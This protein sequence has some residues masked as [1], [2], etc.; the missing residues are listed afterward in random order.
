MF[1]GAE[2]RA[3]RKRG[4]SDVQACRFG[5][6]CLAALFLSAPAAR[7]QTVGYIIA[8]QGTSISN[9]SGPWARVAAGDPI[10]LEF[11]STGAGLPVASGLTGLD[12]PSGAELDPAAWG[13][14]RL[15]VTGDLGAGPMVIEAAIV[16]ASVRPVECFQIDYS[17]DG[18]ID[19]GDYTSS[20]SNCARSRRRRAP[21]KSSSWRS[22]P[23]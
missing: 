18:L 9:P 12:W 10:G 20:W 1:F 7:A 3:L 16:S 17:E 11:L 19:F 23:C 22:A 14:A 8:G 15:W 4:T 5:A 21:A 6:C 13:S 2:R